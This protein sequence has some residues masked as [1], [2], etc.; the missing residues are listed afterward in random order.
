M[1]GIGPIVELIGLGAGLGVL[2]LLGALLGGS[3]PGPVHVPVRTD[4]HPPARAPK[5]R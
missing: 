4:R 5:K 3:R 2:G 1:G